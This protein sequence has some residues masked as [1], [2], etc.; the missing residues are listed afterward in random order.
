MNAANSSDSFSLGHTLW[1]WL[2]NSTAS[3]S[4]DSATQIR[5]YAFPYG[6]LGFLAHGAMFYGIVRSSLFNKCPWNWR[7]PLE[8]STRDLIFG[9]VGLLISCIFAAGTM[10]RCSG[11]NYFVLI[12]SSKISTTVASSAIGINIAWNI[13]GRRKADGNQPEPQTTH[14]NTLW[15]LVFNVVG[16]I[17]E[18]TGVIMLLR[19]SHDAVSSN[20][21]TVIVTSLLLTGSIGI[22]IGIGVTWLEMRQRAQ[23]QMEWATRKAQ[24]KY[25]ALDERLAAFE[26]RRRASNRRR[27]DTP[28]SERRAREPPGPDAAEEGRRR[29]G[30]HEP[31]DDPGRASPSPVGQ[32]RDI[33]AR[34]LIAPADEAD[35]AEEPVLYHYQD[36]INSVKQFVLVAGAAF[37]FFVTL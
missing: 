28:N 2:S 16:S 5:C 35:A 14:R 30:H 3:T 36:V 11:A 26:P 27:Q 13:R 22:S 32:R 20:K 33:E 21:T 10:K 19:E 29:S 7:K 37:A 31:V 12:A 15:W 24:T 18:F 6:L 17:L 4:T 8:H 34:G 23:R 1:N 25:A 9:I